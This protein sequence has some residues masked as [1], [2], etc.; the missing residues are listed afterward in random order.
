MQRRAEQRIMPRTVRLDRPF[1][2]SCADPPNATGVGAAA[3]YLRNIRG[4]CA[5]AGPMPGG[6]TL[7]LV[8][9][10]G[11][12]PAPCGTAL[13]VFAKARAVGTH[14]G[15]LL[16]LNV[17][18]HWRG[19][20]MTPRTYVPWERKVERLVWR[21][22]ATGGLTR[23]DFVLNLSAQGGHSVAFNSKLGRDVWA[24]L[25]RQ[26]D[27]SLPLLWRQMMGFKY[28]L[29]LEGND[30]ATNLK[31]LMAHNSLVLMPRPKS[32]S[33]LM[34]GLLRP[35]VHYVPLDSPTDAPARLRWARAHD[36]ES[37]QIVTNANRWFERILNNLQHPASQLLQRN[38]VG[39]TRTRSSDI[40]AVRSPSTTD[41]AQ[42]RGAS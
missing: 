27:T 28:V 3:E 13:P 35:W 10:L 31:W 25:R 7:D 32:E 2:V 36:R 12:A 15:V 41:R 19:V 38:S 34:E 20:R 1:L 17:A 21:G 6:W 23:R 8:M 4:L 42:V 18:R 37:R 14:C 5:A 9:Q 16:P 11:D 39:G 40:T 26:A 29:S 33:W 24:G 22:S 30:V